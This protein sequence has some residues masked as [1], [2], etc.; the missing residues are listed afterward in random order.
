MYSL[1]R[2][3]AGERTQPPPGVFETARRLVESRP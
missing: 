3:V 2:F 1:P